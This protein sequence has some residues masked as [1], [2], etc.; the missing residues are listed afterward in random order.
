MAVASAPTYKPAAK[1]GLQADAAISANR[2]IGLNGRT[3]T[4]GASSLGVSEY[5]AAIGQSFSAVISGTAL[6]VAGAP[7]TASNTKLESD[8]TGRAIPNAS[9]K[10]CGF[11]VPGSTAAVAGDLIE[12]II[13]HA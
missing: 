3:C 1:L 9:G 12:V 7:I 13:V 10:I 5:E 11:L 6:V 4:A 2:F 8:A